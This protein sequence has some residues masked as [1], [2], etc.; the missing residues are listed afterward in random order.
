MIEWAVFRGPR[1]DLDR[2][3]Y[4]FSTIFTVFLSII[5]K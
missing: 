2:S 5:V 3:P 1:D 4:G